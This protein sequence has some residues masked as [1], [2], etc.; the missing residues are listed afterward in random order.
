MSILNR[1][2][3]HPNQDMTFVDHIEALRWHAIRIFLAVVFFAIFAFIKIEWIF[4]NIILGPTHKNFP[5]Y[6]VMCWLALKFNRPS[7]CMGD[8]PI[9]F[10]ST[11]LSTQF[12]MSFSSAFIFGFIA[13]CPYVFYE[14]WKFVKPALSAYELQKSRGIIFWVTFLF[15]SGIAFGYF[16]LAPYTINFFATYQLSPQFQNI[17]KIDDYLDTLIGLSLGTGLVFQL[18]VLV[19]FLSKLGLFTPALMRNSRRYAIAIIAFVAAVITPPDVVSMI[20]VAI[21]ITLL[22]EI[23]IGISARVEIAKKKKEEAFFNS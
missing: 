7:L 23:S 1:I 21:P 3:K 5:S 20:V 6:K 11:Q 4:N 14:I 19:Y 17:F 16:I 8:V 18:P 10:Q 2:K 22:Y 12:M 15:L 13:A 9:S